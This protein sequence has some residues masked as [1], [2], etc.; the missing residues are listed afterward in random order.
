MFYPYHFIHTILSATILSKTIL[1][2]Y[3]FVHTILSVLFCPLPFCPRTMY[4]YIRLLWDI[5]NR[6]SVTL[7]IV[8]NI[9]C[10]HNRDNR[11][12][13][14]SAKC[15]IGQALVAIML[16]PWPTPSCCSK[17]TVVSLV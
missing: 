16:C 14:Q 15:N 1:A 11:P 2:V 8:L 9:G 5:Q 6:Q 3:H 10:S 7:D 17:I 4:R 13:E 12:L